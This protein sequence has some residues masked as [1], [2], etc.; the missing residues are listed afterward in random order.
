MP[1]GLRSGKKDASEKPKKTRAPNILWDKHTEWTDLLV[2][3]L[4]NHPDFRAKLDDTQTSHVTLPR[5]RS[6]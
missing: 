3:Y 5:N 2:E 6:R 4:T 1:R